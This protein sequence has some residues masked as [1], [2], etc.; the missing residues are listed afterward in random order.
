MCRRAARVP[1]NAETTY[2]ALTGRNHTWIARII[3]DSHHRSEATQFSAEK[4]CCLV[5]IKGPYE[6]GN[7]GSFDKPSKHAHHKQTSTHCSP[8]LSGTFG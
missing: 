4:N 8:D 3:I 2:L 1:V 6:S 7:P 5:Y